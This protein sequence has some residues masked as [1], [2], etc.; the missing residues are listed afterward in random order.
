MN[1]AM[2]CWTRPP[3]VGTWLTPISLVRS[4]AILA[5]AAVQLAVLVVGHHGDLGAGA[6]ADLPVGKHIAAVLGAAGQ[7]LVAGAKGHRV[8]RRGQAWVALSNRATSSLRPPISL[9]IAS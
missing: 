4:L 5:R 7:D 1:R 2:S 8:E 3:L 9:A 6:A